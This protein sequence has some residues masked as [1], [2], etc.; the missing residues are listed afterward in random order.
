MA[1]VPGIFYSL[2]FVKDY[3][4][5]LSTDVC[6]GAISYILGNAEVKDFLGA[7]PRTFFARGRPRTLFAYPDS[8][9]YDIGNI[10]ASVKGVVIE[11]FLIC[12][13]MCH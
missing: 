1:A 5:K 9:Y 12:V 8:L 7:S 2:S 13:P 3:R 6:K 4:L 10:I 11:K